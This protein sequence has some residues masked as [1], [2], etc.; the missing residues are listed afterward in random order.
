MDI[1]HQYIPIEVKW[2]EN[3]QRSDCRHLLKFIA[4]YP[5]YSQAYLVCRC[6]QPRL[7]P[8]NIVALPWQY[9]PKIMQSGK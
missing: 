8:E 7:L 5:C 6:P 4:E 9:L 1:A 2:T 3:P